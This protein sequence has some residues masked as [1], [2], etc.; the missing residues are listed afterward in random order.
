MQLC[1]EETP[2]PLQVVAVEDVGTHIQQELTGEQVVLVVVLPVVVMV[3]V[4]KLTRVI[5][6]FL[7]VLVTG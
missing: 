1:L 4:K 7:V 6:L 2:T 3:L 5:Q